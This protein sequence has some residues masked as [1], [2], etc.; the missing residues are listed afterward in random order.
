MNGRHVQ[1]FPLLVKDLTHT[2]LVMDDG[3]KLCEALCIRRLWDPEFQIAAFVILLG[4]VLKGATIVA[5]LIELWIM[6]EP[7]LDGATDDCLRI[8]GTV[9]L[10][11]DTAIDGAR[12][13]L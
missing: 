11:H 6:I 4:H 12:L 2:L 8:D 9:S 1:G 7:V 3:A 5:F 10:C 13:G